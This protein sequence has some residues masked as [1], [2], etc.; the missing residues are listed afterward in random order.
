MQPTVRILK[1]YQSQQIV[2]T[3]DPKATMWQCLD[4]YSFQ[5]I[6]L[7]WMT[8]CGPL[9]RKGLVSVLMVLGPQ[10]PH[11]GD[12]W[13]GVPLFLFLEFVP[14]TVFCLIILVFQISVTSAPMPCFIMYAEW[15]QNPCRMRFLIFMGGACLCHAHLRYNTWQKVLKV[16]QS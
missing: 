2:N 1:R 6:L 16:W 8:M 5:E 14:I 7:N 13:Y 15:L 12:A 3:F 10:W 9:N 4:S 11:L